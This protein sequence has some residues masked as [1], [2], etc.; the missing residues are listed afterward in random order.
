METITAKI[1]GAAGTGKTTALLEIMDKVL[2]TDVRDPCSI[3]FVTF[4][5]AGRAEAVTR[6]AARFGI[7]LHELEAHG[8]FRTLHS[9]CY[10]CLGVSK[11]ELLTDTVDDRKWMEEAVGEPAQQFV[12]SGDGAETFS[13]DTDA[14]KSLSL[15]SIARNRLESLDETWRRVNRYTDCDVPAYFTV[16]SFVRRYEESKRKDGRSDFTDL[17]LRFSGTRYDPRDGYAPRAAPKEGIA[18]QIPVWFADEWQD[19]SHLQAAVFRRL[20]D[21]ARWRYLVADPFQAIY[22]FAGSDPRIFLD[23]EASKEKTLGQSFRC[24]KAQWTVAENIMRRTNEFYERGIAAAPHPGLVQRS[25]ISDVR[26]IDPTQNWLVI[27]R[28]NWLCTKLAANLSEAGIPFTTV[29]RR[30][31]GPSKKTRGAFSLHSV[32]SGAT[33][34][35]DEWE[36]ALEVIPAATN[37][38]KQLLV[39]GTKKNWNDATFRARQSDVSISGLAAAGAT[40]ALVGML[41]TGEWRSLLDVGQAKALRM[42][43]RHGRELVERP[44]VKLGTIH[45][46]K[47]AEADNVFLLDA[48]TPRVARG[49]DIGPDAYAEESRVW[50]VGATRARHRLVVA[51][52]ERFDGMGLSDCAAETPSAFLGNEDVPRTAPKKKETQQVARWEF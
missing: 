1:L 10:R 26:N 52:D 27:A 40:E 16:E 33:L 13:A 39:R 38:G 4:T 7:P 8:W 30:T 15:W 35:P 41:A 22:A 42:A 48:L 2:S 17:L 9:C 47:G 5:R 23:W 18:P 44:N 21:G 34:S 14:G 43:E 20:T 51:E 19:C 28:T 50:Y 37:D 29:D 46:V 3:G 25:H 49:R 6:A 11:D 45:S 24:G 31:E 32:A 12:S 36:D